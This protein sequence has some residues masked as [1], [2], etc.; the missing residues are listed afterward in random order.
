MYSIKEKHK[1]IICN[2]FQETLSKSKI[3]TS[4]ETNKGSE[5]AFAHE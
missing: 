3:M 4:T 5:S 2:T 1:S